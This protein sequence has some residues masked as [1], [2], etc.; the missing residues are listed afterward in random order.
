MIQ[1]VNFH[2]NK[3]KRE[4]NDLK[5]D[6]NLEFSTRLHAHYARDINRIISELAEGASH[7]PLITTVFDYKPGVVSVQVLNL[8]GGYNVTEDGTNGPH[9]QRQLKKMAVAL[10]LHPYNDNKKFPYHMRHRMMAN[11]IDQIGRYAILRNLSL[12]FPNSIPH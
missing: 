4:E 8:V 12:C 2:W 6:V 7:E 1:E 9:R 3:H 5:I 11:V 10:S